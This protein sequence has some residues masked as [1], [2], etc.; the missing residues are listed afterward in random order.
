MRHL[1]VSLSQERL[2]LGG[3][4]CG[5]LPMIA[6]ALQDGQQ[7]FESP[8]GARGLVGGGGLLKQVQLFVDLTRSLGLS[9]A[10]QGLSGFKEV[11]SLTRSGRCPRRSDQE[12]LGESAVKLPS[13]RG[14]A[15][16]STGALAQH[17]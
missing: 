12:S 1:A 10:L 5:V 3:H 16:D 6:P 4:L 13:L 15:A 17:F 2:H 7:H 8:D 11:A 9:G 14:V